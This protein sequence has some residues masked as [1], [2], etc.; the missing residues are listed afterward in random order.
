LIE[1]AKRQLELAL[2]RIQQAEE[3]LDEA[4]YLFAGN[5]SP[6]SVINRDYYS[7]FYSILALLIF[8]PYSSSKHSGVLSYFN[9]HFI[10]SGIV[11]KDIG[12]A[13]N[14]AFDIRQ[15][16]DY[17]EQISLNSTQV[18]PFIDWAEKLIESV[19]DLL[20]SSGHI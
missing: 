12:R 6:R 3:S 18:E 2:Y 13:V 11:P 15:R 20:K 16:G 19:R 4:R 8:E 10:K 1:E 5:K 7:M 14:K 17:R 9:R